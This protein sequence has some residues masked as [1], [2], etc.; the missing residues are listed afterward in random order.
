ME[1]K[2]EFG[3][4][5]VVCRKAARSDGNGCDMFFMRVTKQTSRFTYLI[6]RENI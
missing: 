6:I 3:D 5:A 1:R 4:I 2:E